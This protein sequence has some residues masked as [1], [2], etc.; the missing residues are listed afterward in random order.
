[1]DDTMEAVICGLTCWVLGILGGMLWMP[2][3][4]PIVGVL[5]CAGA[6]ALFACWF[7]R[8]LTKP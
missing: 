4:H 8:I 1:M 3:G 7:W 5:I 6:L 2:L